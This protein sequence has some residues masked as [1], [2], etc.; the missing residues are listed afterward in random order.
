MIEEMSTGSMLL[1][2]AI[3]CE[4]KSLG[5]LGSRKPGLGV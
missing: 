2:N 1:K 5:M 4:G 3:A